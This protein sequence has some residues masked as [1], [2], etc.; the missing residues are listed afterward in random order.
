MARR[1][2]G[3]R[4]ADR[5]RIVCCIGAGGM[6]AVYEAVDG[7]LGRAVAL[8]LLE[9]ND[10]NA[11][12]RMLREAKVVARIA[13]PNVVALFDAGRDGDEPYL[14]MELLA[15]TDL[16]RVIATRAPLPIEDAVRWVLEA[17][18]GVG[19]AHAKNVVHRD[20]KPS[21][22]FLRDD[23]KSVVVLD[24]GASRS[25]DVESDALTKTSVG[26]GT[27]LYSAPE[28]LADA[29]TADARSDV[30]ALGLVLYELL[31][32]KR[33]FERP[34]LAAVGAAI[35]RD[36]APPI[37]GLPDA[38]AAVIRRCLE[39]NAALRFPSVSAFARALAPW[40][41]SEAL[42]AA[43]VQAEHGRSAPFA[44]VDAASTPTVEETHAASTGSSP[45]APKSARIVAAADAPPRTRRV[46]VAGAIA[47]L[48]AGVLF[49]AS[50]PSKSASAEPP[51][52][53]AVAAPPLPTSPQP[54]ETAQVPVETAPVPPPAPAHSVHSTNV[55]AHRTVAPKKVEP[56]PAIEAEAP[57]GADAGAR[58]GALERRK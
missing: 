52:A 43:V 9:R 25:A 20:L 11:A 1:I 55:V 2:E 56:A 10:P 30:W 48:V 57:A 47:V 31:S 15:G 33:P 40:A 36:E 37:E 21:N 12:A 44:E 51:A 39:K 50:R 14:V 22:L 46:M 38:L 8:K 49:V 42:V 41:P 16:A 29:R 32:G 18:A 27:P 24:F 28:Q 26:I 6:G 19:A 17:A 35:V 54:S 58:R 53:S 23:T 5:Y 3:D 7:E 34:T 45:S 13:H 4:V